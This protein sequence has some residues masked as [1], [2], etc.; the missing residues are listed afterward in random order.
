MSALVEQ[1]RER[2]G[3]DRDRRRHLITPRGRHGVAGGSV[4]HRHQVGVSRDPGVCHIDSVVPLIDGDRHGLVANG[5]GE[6]VLAAPRGRGG[7]AGGPI[8]DRDGVAGGRRVGAAGIGHI[9][10]VGQ[11]VH[12][13]PRPGSFRICN[14]WW[15]LPTATQIGCIAD[16][17]VDD[18]DGVVASVRYVECAR[19][20]IEYDTLWLSILPDC[21]RSD[22]LCTPLRIARVARLGGNNR[23]GVG[24]LIG[25]VQRLVLCVKANPVGLLPTVTVGGKEMGVCRPGVAAAPALAV[26]ERASAARCLERA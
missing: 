20:R 23:E 5:H 24:S 13:D 22:V 2:C 1:N 26:V 4:D 8:D 7:V 11:W 6:Q 3:A 17:C 9:D 19:R 18:R 15:H 21:H 12:R 10:G 25:R 16:L 14:G